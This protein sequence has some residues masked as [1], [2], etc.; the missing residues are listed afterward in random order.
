MSPVSEKNVSRFV[1]GNVTGLTLNKL[2]SALTDY[3]AQQDSSNFVESYHYG[4]AFF[5][6]RALTGSSFAHGMSMSLFQIE[7]IKELPFGIG[8]PPAVMRA[9]FLLTT[10]LMGLYAIVETVKKR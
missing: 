3:E 2:W 4:I 10:A 8:K 6:W 9:N 1:M 7:A 5:I